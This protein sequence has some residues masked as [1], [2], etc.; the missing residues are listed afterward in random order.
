VFRRAKQKITVLVNSASLYL[1]N[2]VHRMLDVAPESTSVTQAVL[3]FV[4]MLAAAW[5]LLLALILAT[6]TSCT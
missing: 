4:V 5:C 2:L 3:T 6:T 1:V